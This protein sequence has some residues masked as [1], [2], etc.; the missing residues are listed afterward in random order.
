MEMNDD[1]TPALPPRSAMMR[2]HITGHADHASALQQQDFHLWQQIPLS[3]HQ[4][5]ASV[6][7]VPVGIGFGNRPQQQLWPEHTSPFAQRGWQPFP[8]AQQSPQES[9][10][11]N[12]QVMRSQQQNWPG[13]MNQLQLQQLQQLIWLQQQQ[14]LQLQHH[15]E[16]ALHRLEPAV[17]HDDMSHD[18]FTKSPSPQIEDRNSP[19]VG[20]Q[21][22]HNVASPQQ[23]LWQQ[24]QVVH[25]YDVT[26]AE[27][28]HSQAY[29]HNPAVS[30]QALF[31]QQPYVQ[32]VWQPHTPYSQVQVQHVRQSTPPIQQH[33]LWHQQQQQQLHQLQQQ[34]QQQRQQSI[35]I[36]LPYS[37]PRPT[38]CNINEKPVFP[39]RKLLLQKSEPNIYSNRHQNETIMALSEKVKPHDTQ[40][41]NINA[42]G[43]ASSVPPLSLTSKSM[44]MSSK[45]VR[46][47]TKSNQIHDETP[48]QPPFSN[49]HTTAQNILGSTQ[50]LNVNNSAPIPHNF[51]PNPNVNPYLNLNP[52]SAMNKALPG[53]YG[54]QNRFTTP[55]HDGGFNQAF[56]AQQLGSRLQ[57]PGIRQQQPPVNNLFSRNAHV[58][59]EV[60]NCHRVENVE[61]YILIQGLNPRTRTESVQ[62]YFESIGMPG[63]V[64]N[65]IL[66]NVDHTEALV[67]FHQKPDMNKL[68]KNVKERKLDGFSLEICEV[69][70]P[71][72]IVVSSDVHI[73]SREAL[74][75]YFG[76]EGGR[77]KK[78]AVDET[79]DGCCILEFEDPKVV[80]KLCSE[81]KQYKVDNVHLRVSPY[82]QCENGAI[83]DMNLH[84]VP[85]PKSVNIQI[86]P[87]QLQFVKKQ[88]QPQFS[89]KLHD[90][91]ADISFS[92]DHVTV[93]CLL[94]QSFPNYRSLVRG[95]ETG[96]QEAVAKFLAGNIDQAEINVPDNIW[97]KVIVWLN[98]G[99]PEFK[100]ILIK[101]EREKNS[102]KLV[103]MKTTFKPAQQIITEKVDIL[104][105]AAR[106]KSESRKVKTAEVLSVLDIQGTFNTLCKKFVDMKISVDGNEVTVEGDQADIPN[107]FIEI[108]SE[109][110]KIE[111]TKFPHSNSREWVQFLKKDETMKYIQKKMDQKNLIGGWT[112][113]GTEVNVYSPRNMEDINSTILQSVKEETVQVNNTCAELLQSEVWNDF[114]LDMHRKF[115]GKVE[116][117]TKKQQVVVVGTDDVFADVLKQ[118]KEFSDEK[119]E[120]TVT[121]SCEPGSVWLDFIST[122]WTDDDFIEIQNFNVAVKKKANGIE[123]TGFPDNL[124]KGKQKLDS[125]IKRIISK[126]HILKKT[127]IHTVLE[128]CKHSGI[129]NAIEKECGCLIKL[130][131]G[132]EES[133]SVMLNDF[134]QI[135]AKIVE[136]D[137]SVTGNSGAKYFQSK[138]HKIKIRL[139][140][141]DIAVQKADMIVCSASSNLQHRGGF[142]G[143]NAT[144]KQGGTSLLQVEFDKKYPNGVKNGDVA[145]IDYGNL[146]GDNVYMT[147]LPSW[148]EANNG[149]LLRNFLRECLRLADQSSMK[150]LAFNTIETVNLGY[151]QDIVAGIM[152][153]AVIEFDHCYSKTSL[154]EVSIV[155]C[156]KDRDSIKAFE[157]HE[158]MRIYGSVSIGSLSTDF[159]NGKVKIELTVDDLSKQQVDAL[160]C[161]VA[162]DMNL[163]RST[164]C[165][166]LV[167]NGGQSLQDE[168]KKKFGNEL[169]IGKIVDIRG[170]NLPCK[171]VF[172]TVLPEYTEPASAE[173]SLISTIQTVLQIAIAKGY[174]SLAIPALGTGYLNFPKNISARCMYDAVLEW[175]N[176]TPLSSIKLVRFV[177]YSKDTEAQQ[178][179]R[180][181]HL[182]CQGQEKR[183]NRTFIGDGT[184]HSTGD[185]D[186][187]YKIIKDGCTIGS[188][189]LS[190]SIGDLLNNKVDAIVN[191]V[192]VDFEM[193]G[194]LAQALVK[195]CPNVLPECQQRKAELKNEGVVVT[196]GST[197]LPAKYIIHVLF[198]DK[199]SGWRN[200]MVACLEQADT[201]G[202]K[203]IAFPVLGSG[204]GR[205]SFSSDNI[206]ECLFTAIDDFICSHKQS[207][208]T[209]VRL[210]IFDKNHLDKSPI[211][212]ALLE[213]ISAAISPLSV[214][215]IISLQK[216]L[217]P[218]KLGHVKQSKKQGQ[219]SGKK[220]STAEADIATSV[221]VTIF[222][223]NPLNIDKCIQALD[224]RLSL[225]YAKKI[226]DA[227]DMEA[228][229]AL[230]HEQMNSLVPPDFQVD[231]KFDEKCEKFTI[232]GPSRCVTAAIDF[233]HNKMRQYKCELLNKDSAELLYTQF[234]WHWLS[235]SMIAAERKEKLYDK[236][237]N[238]VIE[239]AF[240]EGKQCI[241]LMASSGRVYIIDFQKLIEYHKNSK[242]DFV[243]VVRKEILKTAGVTFPSTWMSMGMNE[244]VKRVSLSTN[245]TDYKRIEKHFLTQVNNGLY[246]HQQKNKPLIYHVLKIER[247]QNQT[248]YQQY[249][250][251]KIIIKQQ[252]GSKFKKLERQLWHGTGEENMAIIINHGFNRSYCGVHGIQYGQG[253]YFA[254]DAS[255]SA[256]HYHAGTKY[257]S[258]RYMFLA[259]VLMGQYMKGNPSLRVL[260]AVESS[261][262]TVLYDS[263]VDDTN[264]PTEFVIFH[265][266]QAYPEYLVTFTC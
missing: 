147:S 25:Q 28:Q 119:S 12:P 7:A 2:Q 193:I 145:V 111:P 265:D 174:K 122:C 100:E 114:L 140:Q 186:A 141:G 101:P 40:V 34:H 113:T 170:G 159:V 213:R 260:P 41:S 249:E 30:H 234:Q 44:D 264:N 102:I 33:V 83:W 18:K 26:H 210:I 47:L 156:A 247:I 87:D 223:D 84:V 76:R 4:P 231:V 109:C 49:V 103:G 157:E 171:T 110:D 80:R 257:G 129:I 65:N 214:G 121:V 134:E 124:I 183:L 222:S 94:Q 240:K 191:C 22:I 10:D 50:V 169:H 58:P 132:L 205:K 200:K 181:C 163:T 209:D 218:D 137:P 95:W 93:K 238:F 144:V 106:R 6:Q 54:S 81:K 187:K 203:S 196:S 184:V 239:K 175:V 244:N 158:H 16:P 51:N 8:Q 64:K 227:A 69:P 168:C 57:N 212:S 139:V 259:K 60:S 117:V 3:Q 164:I 197:E 67:T 90:K 79:E 206:A 9:Q 78:N 39:E 56:N 235:E 59:P 165:N 62:N 61:M 232:S 1:N 155:T 254:A 89:S 23:Q 207:T 112:V 136:D 21:Y 88:C 221:Q 143:S 153:G 241:E 150:A 29:Q 160:L 199:L 126:K 219:G 19:A 99:I 237:P 74:I 250:A 242:W 243:H 201:K 73:H 215:K 31:A 179:Y 226:V 248:L 108:Y 162:S 11:I 173:Q 85:V 35:D 189:K 135:E 167:Q 63:M 77:L 262:P 32:P 71:R 45:P 116:V 127:G 195:K 66:F 43:V 36:P 216:E 225:R 230:S 115:K 217:L 46:I 37:S 233:L 266:N 104:S 97:D 261:S 13:E 236:L 52:Q 255:Y 178:S 177:M 5:T 17:L 131:M 70:P 251:K 166:S 105:R 211:M 98:S 182:K 68:K 180:M 246:A 148:K 229:K 75:S 138:N 42:M 258:K 185:T 188:V 224:D 55:K 96:V 253:V 15:S 220:S 24:H 82:Y 208:I 252:K 154:R 27:P 125:K 120:K 176:K 149:K 130:P 256:Q 151:P 107:A 123:L 38:A 204:K 146:K 128:S 142:S 263:T 14:Q 192:G 92:K 198:Q 86:L 91:Y 172:L 190:V 53:M 20:R 202:I 245:S 194:S 161:S 228:M 72:S 118:V 48:S 152:Y 133:T